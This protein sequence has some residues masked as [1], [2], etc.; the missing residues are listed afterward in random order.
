M[1]VRAAVADIWDRLYQDEDTKDVEI[2]GSDGNVR[3]H[4]LV[5]GQMSEIL[6]N[7]L[8]SGMIESQSRQIEMRS[9]TKAQLQF[10]LRLAYTGRIDP[11]DWGALRTDNPPVGSG[12][13]RARARGRGG[14][15]GLFYG[16]GPPNA[17]GQT[18]AGSGMG[19][20][21]VRTH[22]QPQPIPQ[23]QPPPLF[24]LCGCASMAKMYQI[25]G[26]IPM[27]LDK[28]KAHLSADTFDEIMRFGISHDLTPLKLFCMRFAENSASGV[29]QMYETRQLSSE[30]EFELQGLWRSPP[31]GSQ[32]HHF[33]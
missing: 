24:L 2:V 17:G 27:M 6:K 33:Y 23:P 16:A 28:I 8:N 11:T 30:V 31:E 26:F 14:G 5:L 7:M 18:N 29:W 15:T 22:P 10:T 13:G 9:F 20:L 32:Q 12:S 19:G 1:S 25:P 3:A 4:G 21:F